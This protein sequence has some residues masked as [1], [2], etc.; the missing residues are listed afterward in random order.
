M[1]NYLAMA[2][3]LEAGDEVLI[4][5]PAYGLVARCGALYRRG[6]SSAFARTE[7]NGYALDPAEVRR[8]ITPKTRLIV[9]HQSA[10]SVERAD[11][12][13][14]AARGRAI[15]RAAW[16]RVCWW[17]KSISTRSTRTRRGRRSIW[18]RNS[19]SPAA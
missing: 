9:R 13:C 10:Q 2:T 15:W 16:A 4:E 8:A 17:M 12:G 18:A 19:W 7:E 6:T 11:A 14:G 1:A 5:H 3:L